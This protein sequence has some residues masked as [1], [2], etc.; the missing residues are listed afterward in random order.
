MQRLSRLVI[1]AVVAGLLMTVTLVLAISPDRKRAQPDTDQPA[2]P[3]APGQDAGHCRTIAVPD[4]ECE[5]AWEKRRLRFFG[6]KAA[7]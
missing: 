2:K 6:G 1:G 3:A 7:T 5:A 4:A